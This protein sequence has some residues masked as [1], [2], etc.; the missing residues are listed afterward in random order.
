LLY[1]STS[2]L[3]VYL[4]F[5]REFNLYTFGVS[6]LYGGQ[7]N[8]KNGEYVSL[9]NQDGVKAPTKI[10]VKVTERIREDC[11]YMYHGFGVL[12]KEL[13]RAY[14]KGIADEELITNY[15]IDPVMGGTAMRGNFVKII[16][17]STIKN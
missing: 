15:A 9:V 2:S 1:L 17:E 10:K 13:K 16:K 14:R 7:Y 6:S 11:I 3:K 4:C 8:L 5:S 12:A